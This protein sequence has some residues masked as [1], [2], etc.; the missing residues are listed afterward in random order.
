MCHDTAKTRPALRERRSNRFAE[1][2]WA[3]DA[4]EWVWDENDLLIPD[5]ALA[6]DV[7]TYPEEYECGCCCCTGECAAY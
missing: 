4:F 7:E 6:A 1:R 3:A 5:F 2:A